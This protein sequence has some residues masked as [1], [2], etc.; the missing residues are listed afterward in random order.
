MAKQD[1]PGN[2]RELENAVHSGFLMER[3]GWFHLDRGGRRSLPL[4]PRPAPVAPQPPA[5]V[6]PEADNTRAEVMQ[7]EVSAIEEALLL[8][9]GIQIKAAEDLGIS[10]RQ[11]RYRIQKY[12]IKVRKI[13]G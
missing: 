9:K 13:R 10:L 1:W 11:L 6:G 5:W 3:E 8:A 4:R 2:V 12:G 7:E